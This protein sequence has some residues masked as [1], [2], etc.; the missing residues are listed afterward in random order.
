MAKA[1]IYK[2]VFETKSIVINEFTAHSDNKPYSLN[3]FKTFSFKKKALNFSGTI[4][5]NNSKLSF[6][7]QSLEFIEFDTFGLL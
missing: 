2:D 3:I 7:E 5:S 4:L 1:S 6:G